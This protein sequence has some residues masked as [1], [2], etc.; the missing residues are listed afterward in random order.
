LTGGRATTV[1]ASAAH[2]HCER[3]EAIQKH[4]AWALDCFVAALLA[5]T[6]RKTLLAMKVGGA[7]LG[8]TAGAEVV[9]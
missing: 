3:S 2:R 9:S 1:M 8:L 7:R 6:P 5:M 4:R